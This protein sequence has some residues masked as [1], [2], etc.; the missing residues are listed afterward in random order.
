MVD[1]IPN[2][3]NHMRRLVDLSDVFYVDNLIMNRNTFAHLCY[4]MEH[5]GRLVHSKHI[6]VEEKNSHVF[7][8]LAHHKKN[9]IVK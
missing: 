7:I 2:Q 4:L 3:V 8:F 5:K 1:Q 6:N 9:R